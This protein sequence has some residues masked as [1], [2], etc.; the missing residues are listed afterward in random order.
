MIDE[1]ILQNE[2][3]SDE[4]LE[5]VSGGGVTDNIRD[6]YQMYLRGKLSYDQITDTAAVA[7][8]L[9][10]MGYTGYKQTGVFEDNIYFDKEGNQLKGPAF[11]KKFG[12]E[13]G[14]TIIKER[15]A[16]LTKGELSIAYLTAW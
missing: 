13:T 11:W 9:H 5:N 8:V 3:L 14:A 7:K 6:G 10:G 16:T 4:Q 1:K 2:K 12:E 15:E